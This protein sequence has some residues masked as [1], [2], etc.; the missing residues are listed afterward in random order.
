MKNKVW[1][2][3]ALGVMML[4]TSCENGGV[5]PQEADSKNTGEFTYYSTIPI[6]GTCHKKNFTDSPQQHYVIIE[7]YRDPNKPPGWAPY[8]MFAFLPDDDS[9]SFEV[10]PPESGKPVWGYGSGLTVGYIEVISGTVT[11]TGA[12]S[13]TFEGILT[14]DG[15]AWPVTAKGNY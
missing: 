3:L 7:G 9:G 14:E 5:D 4:F 13:F 8:L 6:L 11:K 12:T 10:G 2:V 15:Q 1:S